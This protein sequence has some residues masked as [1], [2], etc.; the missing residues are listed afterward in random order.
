MTLKIEEK[1]IGHL[2]TIMNWASL[3]KDNNEMVNAIVQIFFQSIAA[4]AQKVGSSDKSYLVFRVP[5]NIAK[6]FI[7]ISTQHMRSQLD[8]LKRLYQNHSSIVPQ[9]NTLL[10]SRFKPEQAISDKLPFQTEANFSV[11]DIYLTLKV[12]YDMNE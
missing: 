8:K 10:A 3:F 12:L 7:D 11:D 2:F 5:L 1:L 6:F 4:T 9:Q